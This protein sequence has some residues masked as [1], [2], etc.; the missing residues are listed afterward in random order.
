M[1]RRGSA[2]PVVNVSS[3]L[4]LA[5]ASFACAQGAREAAKPVAASATPAVTAAVDPAAQLKRGKLLYIQ[6]RACHELRASGGHK[7]G[8]HLDSI[9]G[10]KAGKIEGFAFSTALKA[11]NLTWDAPTLDRW[12]AR[13]A[14]VVPGNTMAFA[15][16]PN[17]QDRAALIAYLVADTAAR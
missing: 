14:A 16:M 15:G 11:S 9:I 10:R 5:A 6:C 2:R 8:P 12:L 1:S 17:A 13:P 3:A 7:V 4:L